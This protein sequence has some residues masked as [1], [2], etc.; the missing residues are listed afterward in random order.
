MSREGQPAHTFLIEPFDVMLHATEDG[1]QTLQARF[2]TWLRTLHSPARFLCW[3]MPATLD[4]KIS[5]LSKA[6][7]HSQNRHRAQLLMEYRR[8]F[9]SLDEGAEYQRAL[10]GMALWSD[11][12]P[13][14]LAGAMSS[15]FDTAV[16]EAAWPALY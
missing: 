7:R 16:V 15:A 3:Q 12:N 5:A 11:Q 1:V 6:A 14:A 9:E 4:D 13:R 2:A 10:C 8:Y